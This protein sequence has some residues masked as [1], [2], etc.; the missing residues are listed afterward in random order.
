MPRFK[1]WDNLAMGEL[2]HDVNNTTEVVAFAGNIYGYGIHLDV[3]RCG[4]P[5]VHILFEFLDIVSSD[6]LP[7]VC[8][9]SSS[10]DA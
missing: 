2:G 7:F 6:T 10:D 4:F 5:G 9:Q 3:T 8:Q 1:A